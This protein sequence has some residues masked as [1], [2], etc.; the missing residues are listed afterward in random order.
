MLGFGKRLKQLRQESGLTQ[1]QLAERIWVSKAAVSNYELYDRC[2]TP[3]ILM[4]LARV[5]HVSTDYLLGME[6]KQQTLE[7]SDLTAEDMEIVENLIGLLRRKNLSH[8][9]NSPKEP[10][11]D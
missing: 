11:M 8:E 1:K 9:S 7:V 5:F 2:P 4:K 10:D 6:E 3:E